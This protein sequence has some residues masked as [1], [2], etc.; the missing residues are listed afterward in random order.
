MEMYIIIM[1]SHAGIE[2]PDL[3]IWGN[4]IIL[5]NCIYSIIQLKCFLLM[6]IKPDK[7]CLDVALYVHAAYECFM[8]AWWMTYEGEVNVK[9]Y[10]NP[11]I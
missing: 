2:C 1:K 9:H 5:S 4:W 11:F 8:N 6:Y 7:V 3:G 10:R